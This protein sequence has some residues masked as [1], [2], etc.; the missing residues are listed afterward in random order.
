M[1]IYLI[2]H[3]D[4]DYAADSLTELGFAQAERLAAWLRD[5]P[6][7][8]VYCSPLGRARRTMEPA[9]LGRRLDPK[10]LD[11]LAELHHNM[12][13]GHAVWNVTAEELDADPTLGGRIEAFMAEQQAALV[14]GFKELMA[15]HGFVSTGGRAYRWDRAARLNQTIACF[16]H[17]GMIM[18]LLAGLFRWPLAEMYVSMD[19]KPS[20]VTHLKMYHRAGGFVELRVC[21]LAAQAHLPATEH[22]GL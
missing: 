16:A 17:A 20:A 7:T 18:T 8:A 13:L 6:L 3:A 22:L 11:W 15:R 1:N 4:P 14:A 9:L 10:T 12:G 21:A 5:V 19:Y 2:R